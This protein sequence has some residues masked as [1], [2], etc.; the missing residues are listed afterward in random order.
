M[1]T[2]LRQI[3]RAR[4][5]WIASLG[6]QYL[7]YGFFA[8]FS[9]AMIL[10]LVPKFVWLPMATDRVAMTVLATAAAIGSLVALGMTWWYR[11]SI[12]R[13][14]VEVDLRLKLK[15]R[16]SSV[17]AMKEHLES[18]VAQALVAD[19]ERTAERIDVRDA[20]PLV[21]N[22]RS[23]LLFVPAILA[24]AILWIP[25][26]SATGSTNTS[27]QSLT[28][29]DIENATKPLAALVQQAKEDAEENDMQEAADFYKKL[30]KQIDD[31]KRPKMQD[32]KKLLTDLNALK[33]EMEK[34]REQLGS[35]ESMKKNLASIK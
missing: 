3:Y 20:F 29:A 5:R 24:I 15:E 10:L 14:A 13:A 1:Q 11:P 23:W 16:L 22:P 32:S 8:T 17:L 19:A 35:S 18:G 25:N 31:L 6:F 4:R 12:G 21:L 7:A 28:Q 30:Q 27:T 2:I 9:I 26:A 33:Q 34:R